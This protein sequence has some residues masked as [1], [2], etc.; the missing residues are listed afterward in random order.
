LFELYLAELS[1]LISACASSELTTPK[2]ILVPPHNTG[3]MRV[4]QHA[5]AGNLRV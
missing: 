5:A 4:V 3:Q 2:E 1:G